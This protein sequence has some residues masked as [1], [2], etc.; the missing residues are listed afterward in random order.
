MFIVWQSGLDG[1]RGQNLF[2][3]KIII[4]CINTLLEINNVDWMEHQKL[5][6]K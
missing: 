1:T 3:N 2:I 4:E 6:N 5:K